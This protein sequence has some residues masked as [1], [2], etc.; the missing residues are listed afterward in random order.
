[1]PMPIRAR[2]AR[3]QPFDPDNNELIVVTTFWM[4]KKYYWLDFRGI[5]G[6][7]ME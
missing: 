7:L 6:F 4:N 3:L 5:V 1:M 2:L